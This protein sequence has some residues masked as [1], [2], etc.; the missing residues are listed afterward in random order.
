MFFLVFQGTIGCCRRWRL[1][2]CAVP[3]NFGS[4]NVGRTDDARMCA[5]RCSD[6]RMCLAFVVVYVRIFGFW[7]FLLLGLKTFKS[8]LLLL[9]LLHKRSAAISFSLGLI[10]ISFRLQKNPSHACIEQ[11]RELTY[12]R[13]WFVILATLPTE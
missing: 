3:S 1:V 4:A 13:Q 2:H 11:K 10:T 6:K 12:N 8:L 7:I 9:L 5:H